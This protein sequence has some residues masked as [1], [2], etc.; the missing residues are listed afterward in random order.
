MYVGI[1]TQPGGIQRK[2]VLGLPPFNFTT[3]D[4]TNKVFGAWWKER[5]REINEIE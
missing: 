3:H 2:Q 5:E 1:P 4:T